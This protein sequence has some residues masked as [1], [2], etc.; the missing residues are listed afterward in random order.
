[1]H[2]QLIKDNTI[3]ITD[4]ANKQR[5]IE[6]ISNLDYLV[7]IRVMDFNEILENYAIV[8]CSE[9]EFVKIAK[10]DII[11]YSK[12]KY[13]VEVLISDKKKFKSKY[14]FGVIDKISIEE[15]MVLMIRGDV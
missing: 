8:K 2:K 9:K 12:E 14:N 7:D 6:Y 4:V 13:D 5:V 11:C 10:E 15:L 1:M 3:I